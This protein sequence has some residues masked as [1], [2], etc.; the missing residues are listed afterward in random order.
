MSTYTE[1]LTQVDQDVLQR[2]P[3][4]MDFTNVRIGL[5]RVAVE[6]LI[7]ERDRKIDFAR[8]ALRSLRDLRPLA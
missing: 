7:P 1:T 3:E 8:Q 4:D 2:H 6:E 5:G